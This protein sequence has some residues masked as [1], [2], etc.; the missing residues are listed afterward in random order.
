MKKTLVMILAALTVLA[1]CACGSKT[2]GTGRGNRPHHGGE[3]YKAGQGR[4]L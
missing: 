3:F 4:L 1:L 2:A